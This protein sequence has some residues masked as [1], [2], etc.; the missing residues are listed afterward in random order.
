MLTPE[1]KAVYT[2]ASDLITSRIS[3][4]VLTPEPKAVYLSVAFSEH[5]RFL[6]ISV[7]T[8]EPKAVYLEIDNLTRLARFGISVLTPEPKA[9]YPLREFAEIELLA[10]FSAHP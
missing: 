7:L 2:L 6:K 10:D 1:P 4:S 5:A 8:P 3:I 9:V